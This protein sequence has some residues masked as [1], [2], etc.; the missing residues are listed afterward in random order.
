MKLLLRAFRSVI[1]GFPCAQMECM[2]MNELFH[3]LRIYWNFFMY[4]EKF[5]EMT[6]IQIGTEEEKKTN[7]HTP[8]YAASVLACYCPDIV[9]QNT[10]FR[11]WSAKINH[12]TKLV[13]SHVGRRQMHRSAVLFPCLCRVKNQTFGQCH[14]LAAM[15]G[16]CLARW[17]KN[18]VWTFSTST[19]WTKIDWNKKNKIACAA[20]YIFSFYYRCDSVSKCIYQ[21]IRL[22][23]V[24][25]R[26]LKNN[27]YYFNYRMHLRIRRE[28]L[29]N[30]IA[31]K[32]R[33]MNDSS[34]T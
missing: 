2:R 29:A 9:E 30:G 3:Y 28:V 19:G 20:L 21:N 12:W 32:I 22:I 4:S 31:Y 11:L 5:V 14:G 8:C 24:S 33:L 10:I 6:C 17:E 25:V 26:R 13:W 18:A 16:A 23:Y 34:F 15:C 27:I 1:G 7:C